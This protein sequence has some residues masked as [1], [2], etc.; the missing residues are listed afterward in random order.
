MSRLVLLAVLVAGC[1]SQPPADLRP[2]VAVAARYSLLAAVEPAPDDG[3]C[4]TCRG[5]GKLGDGRVVV[6]CAAC[7]GTG[8]TPKECK[9]GKCPPTSR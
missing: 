4:K 3:I 1:S 5:T 7:G 8:K 9:E 2:F 6:A